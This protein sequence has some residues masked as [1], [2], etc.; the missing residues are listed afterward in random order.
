MNLRPRYR[1]DPDI[2]LISMIDVLLVLLIFF[3]VSTTFNLEG[4]V[5]V[6]LPQAS[7][8]PLPRGAHQPLVVTVTAEGG[9][10]INER[11]L[12]N[13]SPATLRAALLKEAG[14]DRGPIT[15]RADARTT[16]QAVVTVMDVA[17][18]LGFAQLNI[19]TIHE[20]ASP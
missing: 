4:R 11:T 10:R 5:K 8:K 16:H 17:G 6:Q 19:A 7:E 9:Y 3:M 18:R 14:S 1:E 15:I 20:D 13:A 2:N 12:I